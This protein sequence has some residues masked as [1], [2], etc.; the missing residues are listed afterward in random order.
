MRL[1]GAPNLSSTN[2]INLMNVPGEQQI[3]LKVRVAEITRSALRES[4]FGFNVDNGNWNLDLGTLAGGA[5]ISA[6]LSGGDYSLF[7]KAFASNGYGKILAEPTLVTLNGQPAK[8]MAGGEFAVPTAVGVQGVSAVATQF[9]GFGTQL[10]FLPVIMDKDRVR[11]TVSP[12]FSTLGGGRGQ[13]HPDAQ[14]PLGDHHG[15]PPRRTMARP[16]RIDPGRTDRLPRSDSVHRRHPGYRRLLRHSQ[17]ETRR[18]RTVI[19]VSP[20]LVHPLEKEQ[21]PILLPG[22]DVT[23]PTDCAFFFF[24]Q[25]EGV[26]SSHHRS[27]RWP[28]VKQHILLESWKTSH[29]QRKTS[30]SFSDEQSFYVKGP[31]GISE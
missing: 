27:T 21:A 9:K 7:M 2:I 20:E 13:R 24:Q 10:T 14:F 22:M 30:H 1:P 29:A 25:I 18:N 17:Q 4:G 28:T 26:P 11:L 3:L 8:F 12:T 31:S 15:R 5:N 23:D 19:L 6:I 16:R